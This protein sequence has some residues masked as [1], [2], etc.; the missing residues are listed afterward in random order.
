[1]STDAAATLPPMKCPNCWGNGR[2]PGNADAPCGRC[3]GFG[4]CADEQLSRH[5]RLSEMLASSTAAYRGISNA[6]TEEHVANM[7]EL[8]GRLGDPVAD[9]FGGLRVSS[10]YRSESLNHAVR[11]RTSGAHP[12]GM[13]M[14]CHAANGASVREVVE[15]LADG[16]LP[17]DQVIFE[18][19]GEDGPWAHL[20]LFK[21]DGEQRGQVLMTFDGVDYAHFSRRD[22]RVQ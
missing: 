12:H 4:Q 18:H 2:Q 6:P 11:G 14:D 7:R 1:M 20:A 15:F 22:P 17:F 8:C 13:A 5:F 21:P 16:E 10:G 9:H 19:I 3:Q